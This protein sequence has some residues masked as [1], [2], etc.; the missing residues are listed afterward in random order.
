[1]PKKENKTKGIS[2]PKQVFQND[3]LQNIKYAFSIRQVNNL[4]FQANRRQHMS[5]DLTA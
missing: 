1:M 4:I 5:T 2:A 3:R